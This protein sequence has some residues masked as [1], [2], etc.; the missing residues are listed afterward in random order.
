MFTRYLLLLFCFTTTC[1]LVQAQ[2]FEAGFLV[3]STGDTLRG[4]IENNFW[5]E[6]PKE[7][8]FR[9]GPNAAILGVKSEEISSFALT[10]GRNFRRELLPLDRYAETQVARLPMGLVFNQKQELILAEVLV[11]GTASLLR[12]AL[13]GAVHYWIRREKQEYIELTE[14]LYMR[15]VNGRLA[16]AD[17]NN[18]KA[19]LSG[20]FGD[21]PLV[22]QTTESTPYT[23]AGLVRLVQLYNQECAVSR[24]AGTDFTLTDTSKRRVGFNG[25][26]LTGVR[27]NT[28]RLRSQNGNGTRYA[29]LDGLNIDNRPHPLGGLYLDVLHGGRQ[30]ALHLDLSVSTYGQEGKLSAAGGPDGRYVWR[31]TLVTA[32]IGGRHFVPI[33][34]QSRFFYGTGILFEY[35][36]K[37]ES[38]LEYMSLNPPYNQEYFLNA[39]QLS[40][41]AYAEL[42]WRQ[43]RLTI[44]LD[45]CSYRKVSY[46][47]LLS[48]DPLSTINTT[49]LGREYTG[50]PWSFSATIGFRLNNN[51]DAVAK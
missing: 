38:L 15:R 13:Q 42:G 16:I 23:E 50:R 10:P 33:G 47:D 25:G 26:L 46:Y 11:T 32:R 30:A 9:S 7:V 12:V 35:L 19:Q 4:Q 40:S 39:G 1:S 31:G 2:R 36:W 21:C 29:M 45:V 5:V 44:A 41:I 34:Q 43:D 51:P 22:V 3:K 37:Q 17:G 48:V 18:Y 49:Y 27:L 20:Y 6:P 28:F 14:R 24:Q 8:R